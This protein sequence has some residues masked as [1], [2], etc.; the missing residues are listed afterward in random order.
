MHSKLTNTLILKKEINKE[1]GKTFQVKGWEIP[2]NKS[3]KWRCSTY[4]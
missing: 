3:R 1:S 2:G 4:K